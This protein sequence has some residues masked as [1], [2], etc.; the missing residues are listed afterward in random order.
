QWLETRNGLSGIGGSEIGTLF[1]LNPWKSAVELFYHKVGYMTPKPLKSEAA[2]HGT[3]L[4]GYI[5]QLWENYSDSVEG[6]M[7]SFNDQATTLRKARTID[8]ILINPKYPFLFANVDGIITKHPVYNNKLGVLEIKTISH[9]VSEMWEHGIPP[10]Y[11]FQIHLYCLVT[12]CDYAEL[13]SLKDGQFFE[14]IP[15][16]ISRNI[17]E[18]IIER[19]QDFMR[20]VTLG[21]EAMQ[22]IPDE[23]Q[24]LQYLSQLEPDYKD[25]PDLLYQ[26]YSEKHKQR[27]SENIIEDPDPELYLLAK[28]HSS[29][30]KQIKELEKEQTIIKVALQRIMERHGAQVVNFGKDQEGNPKGRITWRKQFRITTSA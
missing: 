13:A 11:L 1:A 28:E 22:N 18:S 8:G 26:F 14:C 21:V 23:D 10:S 19:G 2:F 25:D 15:I 9:R 20:R 7:R 17:Q 5:R 12:G 27:L 30:N 4:E 16:P 3:N 24:L 6:M 29:L